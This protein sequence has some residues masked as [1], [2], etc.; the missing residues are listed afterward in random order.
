M[1][2]ALA[3]HDEIVGDTVEAAG[4]VLLKM[5]GEGDSTFSVFDR[6]S[7]GVRAAYVL[8]RAL[9]SER[10]PP[11]TEIRT[12]AAVHTGEAIERDGD[13]FGPAVN[14]VARLRSATKG[15]Q[16]LLSAATATIVRKSLP[17]GCDLADV[18]LLTLRGIAD[19]VMA[20]ELVGPDLESAAT[21]DSNRS[22]VLDDRVTALRPAV[23]VAGVLSGSEA[24]ALTLVGREWE[25]EEIGRFVNAPAP[26]F[27]LIEG[28]AG[29]GKTALWEAGVTLARDR[30]FRVLVARPVEA[31]HA[32]SFAVLSDLLDG[33]HEE[34]GQ[35]PSQHRRPLAAALL[36]EDPTGVPV[37]PRAIAVGLLT[38][39]RALARR[40][41]LLI[42]VD[43]VQWLDTSSALALSFA[44]RRTADAPIRA[45]LAE[46]AGS[47]TGQRA[48]LLAGLDVQRISVGAL[49]VGAFRRLIQKRFAITL[50]QPLLRRVHERAG[51]NPFYGLELTRA[52]QDR[53]GPISPHDDLPVPPDLRRLLEERL[54]VLP[55]GLT[56][57][58]AM[59][60]A[61]A[62]P[63]LELIGEDTVRPAIDAGVLVLDGERIRF[64]HPLLAAA[65]YSRLTA[66]R[67][68]ALHQHLAGVVDDPEERARH[69]AAAA[70][71]PDEALA[72]ALD[73]AAHLARARGA[74]AAAAELAVHAL[75][76]TGHDESSA[77][78]LRCVAAAE[79]H[80]V[81]GDFEEARTLVEDQ[82]ARETGS[83]DRARLLLQ[84]ARLG[85]QPVDSA[86]RLMEEA[87]ANAEG[88]VALEAEILGG[89]AH[90]MTS[91]RRAS[92]AEPYAER[93]LAL[94]EQA[95]DA[96]LLVRALEVLAT[97]RFWLGRGLPVDLME[98]ALTL[99]PLCGAMR[100]SARPSGVFG[101]MCIFVGDLERARLLLDRARRL[102]EAGSDTSAHVVLWAAGELEFFADD[103]PRSLELAHEIH[104]L[105]IDTEHRQARIVGLCAHA[106]LYAHLGDEDATRT[107][108]AEAFALDERQGS[109][110]AIRLGSWA[111]ALLELSLDNPAGA[112]PYARPATMELRGEGLQEPAL[113][114]PFPVHAEAAIAVG[115]LAEADELIDWAEEH[116]TRLDRAWALACCARCRGLAA[117]ARG[118]ERAAVEAFGRALAEHGRVQGRR[119][120]LARTLLAHGEALRR[121]K[122]KRE[123]RTSIE[124]AVA[125]FD[126]L[127]ARLW[128]A[129]ARG[130]LARISGRTTATGLTE[131]EQ[132]V[133]LLVSQGK[134]NKEVATAMF[135]TV[136][137]VES[138]LTHIYKKL[139][140][141]S[142]TELARRLAT[143]PPQ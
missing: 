26:A 101:W 113:L 51:G 143:H 1:A 117:T 24:T 120:D 41:P 12:R 108:A 33:V 77:R 84:R 123:A 96:L 80:A 37:E 9:Q 15:G 22:P 131:T 89:L 21:G 112:L 25:V 81:A 69:L 122:K 95:D 52:L 34:M 106:V 93:C 60:A 72:A 67:R 66:S 140:V 55:P 141:R 128:S 94:A 65:A 53:S 121:F 8:Q 64:E 47:T 79:H 136:R 129:K 124:N 54:R 90:L 126:E 17:T 78:V 23:G 82:L 10:W 35:L 99:E 71:E 132:A 103:W 125:I 114:P 118:D 63:T 3:R 134:S 11:G 4:G 42:A 16:I 83:A 91:A 2:D 74:P 107:Y 58:L 109:R 87:L 46:R 32:L 19:R 50:P 76:L 14:L 92:D 110:T 102:A 68:R 138:H 130:E 6:A 56:E 104:R 48:E 75:R 62:E 139:G 135:V 133:A 85:D 43:D 40:E 13:Y 88:V 73:E 57:L 116:A 38:L 27:A 86:I 111:L 45:L 39:L 119:F 105:G 100:A 29:I 127:G 5:R 20:W 7:V 70:D 97:N 59:V 44:L 36:L 49:D 142:R 98:R 61:L 18:G 31:E 28:D 30:G 115:E 137:T